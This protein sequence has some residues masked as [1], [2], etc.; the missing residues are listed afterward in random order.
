[1]ITKS[2]TFATPIWTVNLGLDMNPIAEEILKIKAVEPSLQISNAAEGYHSPHMF[3][4]D[5]GT[6]F[7]ELSKEIMGAMSALAN[8]AKLNVKFDVAWAMV[9][10]KFAYN[11]PH[12]HP[13]AAL[14]AVLYLKAPEKCGN[15]VFRNPTPALHYPI[16]DAI[17]HFGGTYS[18]KP[19]VGLLC[20]FPAYLEHYVEPNMSDEERICISLNFVRA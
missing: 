2:I 10:K 1:M 19:K 5:F 16:D 15:L 20:V 7:P 14:S 13:C 17:D 8:E 18:I 12:V 11:V 9:N 3:A 6:R 4:E